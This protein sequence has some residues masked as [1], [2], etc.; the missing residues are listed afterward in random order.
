M[1]TQTVSLDQLARLYAA[2]NEANGRMSAALRSKDQTLIQ[3]AKQ[4]SANWNKAYDAARKQLKRQQKAERK[5]QW[6]KTMINF[7]LDAR[8]E[9]QTSEPCGAAPAH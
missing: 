2:R 3:L 8:D 5:A 1:T 4:D 9:I 6:R 7:Y